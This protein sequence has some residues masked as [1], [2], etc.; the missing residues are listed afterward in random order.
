MYICHACTISQSIMRTMM[1]VLAAVL[2]RKNPF[3]HP[4]QTDW[5]IQTLVL[6]NRNNLQY[7]PRPGSCYRCHP[8]KTFRS[9]R[10]QPLTRERLGFPENFEA[11]GLR[12]HI[13]RRARTVAPRVKSTP[14]MS[15][16]S[17]VSPCH[18]YNGDPRSRTGL[19]NGQAIVREGA[20]RQVI[21]VYIHICR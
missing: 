5:R 12:A 6:P 1:R 15:P 21:K 11:Q 18:K 13:V 4:G 10:A 16:R 19:Q 14:L 9:W 2:S 17:F 8:P 20:Q 3:F 7:F